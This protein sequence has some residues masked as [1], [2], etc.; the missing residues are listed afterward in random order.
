MRKWGLLFTIERIPL[1]SVRTSE[2]AGRQCN[3]TLKYDSL[4]RDFRFLPIAANCLSGMFCTFDSVDTTRCSASRYC[5]SVKHS[6][7][8]LSRATAQTHS[9]RYSLSDNRCEG[10]RPSSIW[11]AISSCPCSSIS[12][13]PSCHDKTSR[14]ITNSGFILFRSTWG[15]NAEQT[16][17]GPERRKVF[18]SRSEE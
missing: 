3:A 16:L 9:S 11:K 10:K 15:S 2:D 5:F 13:V 8:P 18:G 1:V 7:K 17:S 14:Q 12:A 4:I 6:P